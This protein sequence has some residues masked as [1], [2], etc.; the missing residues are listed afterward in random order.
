MAERGKNSICAAYAGTHTYT[1]T[2]THA[3]HIHSWH[4]HRCKFISFFFTLLI[5]HII[6]FFLCISSLYI[7][8]FFPHTYAHTHTHID[9]GLCERSMCISYV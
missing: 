5:L 4:V 7:P 3:D 6:L 8:L 2:C 9:P 1:H